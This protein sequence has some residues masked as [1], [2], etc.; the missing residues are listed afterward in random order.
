MSTHYATPDRDTKTEPATRPAARPT[1]TG[2]ATISPP[3]Q[4]G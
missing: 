4:G 3:P 2:P 1:G